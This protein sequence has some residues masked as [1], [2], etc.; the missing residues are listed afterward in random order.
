MTREDRDARPSPPSH[1][2][3][4]GPFAVER[5]LGEGAF[6]CVYL[7]REEEERSHP[8]A[9][10]VPK[11]LP[12]R[13]GRA[14]RARFLEEARKAAG[15]DHPGIV[16]IL[17]V[18]E[19]EGNPPLPDGTPYI[20]MPY[21]EGGSLA[22]WLGKKAPPCWRVAAIVATVA[23]AVDFA[24]GAGVIHRD[25]KPENILLDGDDRPYV[26]DF[27]IA[28]TRDALR[29]GKEDFGGTPAYMSPELLNGRPIDNR[30]DVWS[31]GV[32]LYAMLTRRLPFPPDDPRYLARILCDDP[33]LPCQLN[34]EIP[35]GLERVCLRCL[36]RDTGRRYKTAGAL[37]DA[38]GQFSRPIQKS[39]NDYNLI[40]RNIGLIGRKRD[41]E[42]FTSWAGARAGPGADPLLIVTDCG[43]AGKSAAAW[44]W[45]CEV[46][47]KLDVPFWGYFWFSFERLEATFTTFVRDAL[48]YATG[49]DAIGI[50]EDPLK[51]AEASRRLL[52][53]LRET[54][55]LVVLDGFE[56]LLNRYARYQ[57]AHPSSEAPA[58]P[59]L[60]APVRERADSDRFANR[61]AREFFKDL[62]MPSCRSRILIT[63]RIFPADLKT[64]S[65]EVNR[66]CRH[67]EAFPFEEEDAL[68]LWEKLGCSGKKENLVPIF[69]SFACHPLWISPGG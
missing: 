10:K 12:G 53:I 16:K 15:L 55:Y 60:S 24:H 5:P 50:D 23:R 33:E 30:T 47:P 52:G 54:P 19:T 66:G 61:T 27:G 37:A 7:A 62:A 28:V 39:V 1:P 22:G 29:D 13:E 6:G 25:L 63:S 57:Q 2:E 64:P 11:L 21:M 9:V 36:S 42:G 68:R 67:V 69:R 14:L 41:L 49:E 59:V 43:G 51:L 3:R 31:L 26:A 32:I 8:V 35:D 48:K 20:V 17:R 34:G 56:L 45:F 44:S 46:A 58:S 38:L 40:D 65:G 18:G 4:I